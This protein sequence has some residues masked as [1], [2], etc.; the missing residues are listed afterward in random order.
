MADDEAVRPIED[1]TAPVAK[2]AVN[3]LFIA[4]AMALFGVF[5]L[6]P[7]GSAFFYAFTHWDGF[8]APRWAG[9]ANFERAFA[10]MVHLESYVH[11]V[12]YIL[13]TLVFEVTFGLVVAVLLNSDRRGFAM[14]RGFFFS[15]VVL[16]MSAA[17]VLWAFVLDYRTGLLNS[18]L[19]AVGAGD[20]A[21]PWLSQ[22]STALLAIT[23]VSGWKYAGFYMVIFFAALRRIPRNLYEAATLDGAG[24]V[25]QFFSITLPLL[26]QN[27]LVAVLLAVTGGFAGFDL[28][29]TMTN[30]NP[31][32]A[33]EV[34]ATWIMKQA[35]DKN[36][37]SY[38]IALT[39]VLTAVVMVIS[40]IYLRV[41]ER[42]SVHRY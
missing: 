5:V 29:F 22:S 8:T 30:G 9:L 26:R 15:P 41:S 40:L 23:V 25:R 19:K 36:Q 12:L 3:L 11:V 35:F 18:V 20:W 2:G 34:P 38:G 4:P 24:A 7:V 13:G 33:T 6:L 21:Q 14:L 42:L 10:D 32:G 31:F 39:V 1:R 16:S 28:F 27:V 17:G 37:L